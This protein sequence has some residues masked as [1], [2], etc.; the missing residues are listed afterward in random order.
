MGSYHAIP[1]CTKIGRG[2]AGG[3]RRGRKRVWE[4]EVV[5]MEEN[6]NLNPNPMKSE[7]LDRERGRGRERLRGGVG[8]GGFYSHVNCMCRPWTGAW[9]WRCGAN[10]GGIHQVGRSCSSRGR[11]GLRVQL[12]KWSLSWAC[13]ERERRGALKVLEASKLDCKG[14]ALKLNDE[15]PAVGVGVGGA[16]RGVKASKM[17]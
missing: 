8:G 14:G 1:G 15:L 2:R 9:N 4:G 5:T 7:V 17:N 16:G 10:G 13:H 6:T 3:R 11:V 12:F